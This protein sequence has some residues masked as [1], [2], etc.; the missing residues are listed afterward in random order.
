MYLSAA[1]SWQC[2]RRDAP[3]AATVSPG[4]APPILRRTARGEHCV[5]AD[6]VTVPAITPP[7][8]PSERCAVNGRPNRP[9]GLSRPA[10]MKRR[11]I[12]QSHGSRQFGRQC[13][14]FIIARR[15]RSSAPLL[16][17]ECKRTGNEPLYS[18]TDWARVAGGGREPRHGRAMPEPRA[19]PGGLGGDPG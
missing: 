15:C 3:V 10:T 2:A 19:Q 5:R 9:N 13:I 8:E 4:S 12:I 16:Y 7:A 17:A 1:A 18:D 11:W 14:Q 6:T